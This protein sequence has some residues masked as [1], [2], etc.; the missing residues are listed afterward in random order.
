[1]KQDPGSEIVAAA[2]RYQYDP[3]AWSLFAWD[4]GQGDLEGMD[5]P[6]EWQRDV[7]SAVRDHL[8]DEQARYQ[9]LLL[10]VASGHGIGKSAWMGMF[11]NWGLSCFADAKIVCTANTDT[12]LRTKTVP[13]VSKW[14]RMS[15][16][17]DWF[18]V[19]A[20]SI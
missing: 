13:E 20:T 14:F 1:M 18:D 8:E 17:A 4:W 6:R 16:T 7:F 11:S 10:S 12:Q 19:Q 3:L 15:I 9:P 5:G 2:A